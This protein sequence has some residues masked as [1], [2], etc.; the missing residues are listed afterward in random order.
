MSDDAVYW[1]A[2]ANVPD[3][4]PVMFRALCE[5]FG[6]P[7]NVFACSRKEL[8]TVPRLGGN[9]IAALLDAKDRVRA[10]R[11][12]VARLAEDDVN[13]I[14]FE[15]AGYPR[16][17]FDLNDPPPLLYALGRLPGPSEH[18]F[19]VAGSTCPS[20]RGADIARSAG[21]E[22][23]A[24]GWT[25]VSGYAHGIDSAAHV[26]ALEGR[27]RTVFVLPMG[28]RA[29]E[30]RPEF[31][32]FRN[33][34]GKDIVLLSECPADSGWSSRHAVLRDRIIAAL[35][36]A[37]LAV[38]ARPDSGTMITFRHALKLGRPAYVVKYRRAPPGA[39][40]NALAIRAGGLPVTS[41]AAFR[42]IIRAPE[43]PGTAPKPRQ[44]ELF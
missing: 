10:A 25:L 19:S 18:T 33:H 9:A 36:R 43:L 3:I 32:R 22:L 26:G 20:A 37:L 4:G 31:E 24:A 44:G 30:L 13:I 28:V 6:G 8:R 29:F 41:L 21:R 14:T 34:L 23:A 2:L 17:L 27:G 15:S 12:I 39:S 11:Q 38:E 1:I 16:S 7:R 35:G 42:E 40:G 5:R